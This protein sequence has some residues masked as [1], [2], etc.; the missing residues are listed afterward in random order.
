M[1]PALRD[2]DI[3]GT[4]VQRAPA[5]EPVHLIGGASRLPTMFPAPGLALASTAHVYPEVVNGQAVLG[6]VERV[7]GGLLERLPAQERQAA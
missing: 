6:V 5:V 4:V 1:F 7:V 2:E 3:L